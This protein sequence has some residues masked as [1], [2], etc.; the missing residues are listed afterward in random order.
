MI[1]FDALRIKIRDEGLVRNSA[2]AVHIARGVRAAGIKEI[3]GLW[4][5]QNEGAK[6]CPRA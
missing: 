6:F 5:E 1:F 4:R 3:L 2:K